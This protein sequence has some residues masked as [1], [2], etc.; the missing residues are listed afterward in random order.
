M[1]FTQIAALFYEST[2]PDHKYTSSTLALLKKKLLLLKFKI[3]VLAYPKKIKNI[4]QS[5]QQADIVFE[6]MEVQV[7][8]YI[9]QLF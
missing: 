6:N 4:F 8:D 7:L 2:R 9:S 3:A 1:K 5:F